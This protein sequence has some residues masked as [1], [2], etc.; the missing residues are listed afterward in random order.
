MIRGFYNSASGMVALQ[1]RMEV[2]TTNLANLGTN[3]FKQDRTAIATFAEQ[4]VARMTAGESV[5]QLGQIGLVE[6]AGEPDT[7]WSQGSLQAT[8]RS[9]DLALSGSGMFTI[10]TP[11][12]VRYTRNGG[13]TRNAQNLLTTSTGRTVLGDNGPIE[14][15]EGEIRV[16][17]DGTISVDDVAVDRL[18]I[19]EF[20]D[21]TTVRR[22]GNNELA[23]DDPAV[24]PRPATA[25]MVHQGMV[26]ASN[27]DVTATMTTIMEIQ[28]AYEANQRMI[29][30][31][32]ELTQRAVSE[33]ARPSA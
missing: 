28:R 21:L 17:S 25:T 15:P 4:L 18:S 1:K 22:F 19:V 11:D 14:L 9:L 2:A 31:Q 3:G 30:T 13:F 10:Q 26:E 5:A 33:I 20:D 24:Q 23:S 12:G 29:Q 16:A 8:G 7:D 6:I 32:N 27:V